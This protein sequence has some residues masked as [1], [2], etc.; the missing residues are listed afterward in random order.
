L[1]VSKSPKSITRQV[2][3]WRDRGLTV[4]LVPTMGALHRG[5][6]ALVATAR[7]QCDRVIATIFVNP[8]QFGRTEDLSRYPRTPA[9]DQRLLRSAGCDLLFS[10]TPAAM[11]PAGY[12]TWVDPGELGSILEGASRPGHFRGV[13]TVCLKL[14]NICRPH[15]AYFGQ[16]DFQ[17]TAVLRA[18]CRDLDVDVKLRICP[19][20][21]D[22]DGLAL[23]SRNRYLTPNERQIALAL[24]QTLARQARRL[25]GGTVSPAGAE[26]EGRRLLAD[27]RGMK[28]DYFV[29]RE[30]ISLGRPT[31]EARRLVLLAAVKVGR[32]R[33]I[34]NILVRLNS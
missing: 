31:P 32:T 14:F 26:R 19:T 13:A 5:H 12:D 2:E 33:L 21:R 16:K 10:P 17:Q 25:R 22:A 7:R 1:R 8:T 6:L 34:D 27:V 30:P 29:V 23:S 28:L 4:G 11:Y 20:V 9:V 24:P 3:E 18:L 15:L